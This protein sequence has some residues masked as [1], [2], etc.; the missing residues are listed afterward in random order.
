MVVW[1][2]TGTEPL[3]D[4]NAEFVKYV[5]LPDWKETSISF[6]DRHLADNPEKSKP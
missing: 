6:C 1:N 2:S 5:T 4:T 3:G